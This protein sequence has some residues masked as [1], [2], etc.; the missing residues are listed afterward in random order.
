MESKNWDDS[1]DEYRPVALISVLHE[2]LEK[3]TTDSFG[4]SETAST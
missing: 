4:R 3:I 2:V 1:A